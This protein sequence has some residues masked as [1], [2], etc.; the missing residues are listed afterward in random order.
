M[1]LHGRTAVF[2]LCILIQINKRSEITACGQLQNTLIPH[3]SNAHDTHRWPWHVAI[4]H[5][6]R[7]KTTYQCGGTL[8]SSNFIITAAH[9]VM[10]APERVSVSLGRLRLN[11]HE[12]TAPLMKVAAI[13]THP[14]Y[15][16]DNN[17]N[18]IAIITLATEAVF[19]SYV[20]PICVWR[21][22]KMDLYEVIGKAGTVVG[23]GLTEKGE[24]SNVLQ[25]ATLP[26]V[27]PLKCLRSNRDLF[28]RFIT[29]TNFCAGNL[30]GTS[31]CSGDSGGSMTF[32][33][34]GTF[35]IRGIVSVGASKLDRITN[36]IVCD[37]SQ[38]AV[39]T[40][41]AQYLPWITETTKFGTETREYIRDPC[42]PSPCGE[43][44]DCNEL[45]GVARCTCVPSY[46]GDAYTTGCRPPKCKSSDDCPS[47]L[48]CI[49]QHC[50]DPCSEFCGVGARCRV[51]EHNPI[52]TCAD[53][54]TGDPFNQCVQKSEQTVEQCTA[55]SGEPG[56]CVKITECIPIQNDI[57]KQIV[58]HV[59]C[60]YDGHLQI[61]CC[62]I[63]AQPVATTTNRPISDRISAR[64]CD[65]YN[66]FSYN[67]ISVSRPP[68][69]MKVSN[70]AHIATPLILGGTEAKLREFPH[71][72][73]I[74]FGDDDGTIYW[75]C[76][77][78]LVSEQF[79]LS[80]AQCI[81]S[82][83]YGPAKYVRLGEHDKN[84]VDDG[85]VIDLRI[86][87]SIPH[88]D[89]H[90]PIRHGLYPPKLLSHR[91]GELSLGEES[92]AVC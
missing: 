50:N 18:D 84:R 51:V 43:N 86:I 10:I 3:I 31:V 65:E 33:E 45:N 58:S 26:V 8:I 44:A 56:E 69:E 85:T 11:S 73:L 87:E 78:T 25:E 38:Y 36:Q 71:M 12:S 82:L 17:E 91:D 13:V 7:T 67:K 80:A 52:C 92:K 70:C 42:V 59:V 46:I 19:N 5:H 48:A 79:V 72:A 22:D 68:V 41:V 49:N 35:Y 6:F 60:G 20:Q 64:K 27:A 75:D 4:Y 39:F 53:N 30:N 21:S 15:I 62:P 89:F 16:E 2:I 81:N 88:P 66:E 55:R 54:Y 29:E 83:S 34:N 90:Y 76:G 23:W 32:Q 24:T 37:T 77:G 47:D 1:K 40:D 9:C 14:E 57:R 63:A 61:V 28:G 74:G